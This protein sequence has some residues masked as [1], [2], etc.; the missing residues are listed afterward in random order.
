MSKH[1]DDKQFVMNEAV[2]QAVL[3]LAKDTR[4]RPVKDLDQAKPEPPHDEILM[5]YSTKQIT[6]MLAV[7]GIFTAAV[8]IGGWFFGVS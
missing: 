6:C 8:W 2:I 5:D 4:N 1:A 3:E 7:V